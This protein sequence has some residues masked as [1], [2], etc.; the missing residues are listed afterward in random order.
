MTA[1]SL[2]RDCRTQVAA[3]LALV[4]LLGA[5]VEAGESSPDAATPADAARAAD[6]HRAAAADAGATD[7][8]GVLPEKVTPAITTDA[9]ANEAKI[10][11]SPA[12][13]GPAQGPAAVPVIPPAKPAAPA[14]R[15]EPL[16]SAARVSLSLAVPS[17]VLGIEDETEL[18]IVVTGA[19]ASP[20]RFPRILCSA[21]R[22]ED[23]VREGPT[24]FSARFLLPAGR[25]PQPAIVVADFS[26][27]SLILRGALA[28]RL[29]AAASPAF[30]TDPGA[31][32]TV[33][34]GDKEFGP[35]VAPADGNIHVPVVVPPG[36]NFAIARSV[37]RA[38]KANQQIL[39]LKIPPAQRALIVAP[40]KLPAGSAG[41][42]AVLA[43]EPSGRLVDAST[44]TLASTG[45]RPQPLG[46]LAQ[47]EARF[48]VR[49]PASL[50]DPTLHLMASLR[51][52]PEVSA[53]ADVVLGSAATAQVLLQPEATR[54]DGVP[55]RRL[56]VFL[57]S[58][59]AFGNPTDVGEAAVLVD[60]QSA[61]P[62]A[63][64]DGRVMLT[65]RPPALLA[66]RES[67]DVEAV[68]DNGHATERIPL[69]LFKRR[70]PPDPVRAPRYTLTPRLGFLWNFQQAPGLALFVEAMASRHPSL[71]GFAFGATF[72]YLHSNI[73]SSNNAGAGDVVLDQLPLLAQARYRRRF[74]RLGLS[75]GAGAGMVLGRASL[76]AFNREI[77]GYSVAFAAEGSTEA[78][79]L[80]HRSQVV[81]GLRY[82]AMSLGKLSSGD[83]IVGNTGGFIVD[84]GYRIG[85]R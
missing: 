81:F 52:Q 16:P 54:P 75:V 62:E 4:L 41:E 55:L 48:L 7:G 46:S 29:R 38:G 39:D 78:A 49:A 77:A 21:G 24:N 82:L 12:P 28:V 8:A 63:T 1:S 23:M 72:G 73:F 9:G 64:E 31:K 30:H 70:L 85:W 2:A 14:T 42:I 51:G 20:L 84:A 40:E 11:Q 45:P 56:R 57:S 83:V 65:L 47:G 43:V 27:D 53:E 19:F 67:M 36:I 69:D 66:V 37:N 76:H 25:F 18:R 34:V 6:G 22:V 26:H 3:G 5:Q 50:Q 35:L 32:V 61:S 44:I 79:L 10:S 80:L 59:D 15:A 74:N 58:Q 17:P 68:L 33:K 13:A 60:G 71:T